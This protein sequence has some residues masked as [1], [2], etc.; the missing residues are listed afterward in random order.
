MNQDNNSSNNNFNGM[1][2]GFNNP[3]PNQ[4]NVF[5]NQMAQNNNVNNNLNG[6]VNGFNNPLPNQNSMPN[7]QQFD[8][9]FQNGQVVGLNPGINTNGSNNGNKK[10][11][12]IIGGVALV[13]ICVLV[14]SIF[15]NVKTITCTSKENLGTM[16]ADVKLSASFKNNKAVKANM[17]MRMDLSDKSSTFVDQFYE[18]LKS[19]LSEQYDSKIVVSRKN[20]IVVAKIE[21]KAGDEMFG[22]VIETSDD[23]TPESFVKQMEADGYTCDNK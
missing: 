8:P 5:D 1:G 10:L 14:Y 12:I 23:A 15:F 13:V 17:E 3:M 11:P 20:K 4:N 7:N 21:V 6:M 2:G 19:N 9:N 18:K 22:D 16:K